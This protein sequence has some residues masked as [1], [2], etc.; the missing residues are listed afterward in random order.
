VVA[1]AAVNARREEKGLSTLA[2][3]AI[4]LVSA[5]HGAAVA[6]KVDDKISSTFLR[7]RAAAASM[8]TGK[9][10]RPTI[11]KPIVAMDPAAG[12]SARDRD[13]DAPLPKRRYVVPNHA[14]VQ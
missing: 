2:L 14:S 1:V 7:A 12:Q 11:A 10:V 3:M 6:N 8:T 4:D 13:D 5:Q 9:T